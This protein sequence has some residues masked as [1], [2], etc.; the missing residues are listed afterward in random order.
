M[1]HR[2][3]PGLFR[4]GENG[5]P[6]ASCV[7]RQVILM[8]LLPSRQKRRDGGDAYASAHV[9]HQ[10]L[11]LLHLVGLGKMVAQALACEPAAAALI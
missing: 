11:E 8:Q 3:C 4:L 7:V 9:G 6:T 10:I 1:P 5:S 2:A